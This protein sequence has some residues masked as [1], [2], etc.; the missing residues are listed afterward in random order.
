MSLI[1]LKIVKLRPLVA[2]KLLWVLRLNFSAFPVDEELESLVPIILHLPNVWSFQYYYDNITLAS[3]LDTFG[4]FEQEL[5]QSSYPVSMA[6]EEQLSSN[7]DSLR[8]EVKTGQ[9]DLQAEFEAF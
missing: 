6:V 9:K 1:H 8:D 5:L 2:S 3:L 7:L 4:Y